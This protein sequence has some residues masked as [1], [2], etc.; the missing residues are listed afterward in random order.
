[1]RK[2]LT[3]DQIKERTRKRQSYVANTTLAKKLY[4]YGVPQ[5]AIYPVLRDMHLLKRYKYGR[6]VI[7]AKGS[8]DLIKED[9]ENKIIQL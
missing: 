7:Y 1:M 6:N 3:E 9:L 8:I 4:Q 2:Q 5:H